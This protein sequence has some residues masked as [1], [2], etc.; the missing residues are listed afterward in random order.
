MYYNI[1]NRFDQ[2]DIGR[3]IQLKSPLL[4]AIFCTLFFSSLLPVAVVF[5]GGGGRGAYQVGVYGALLD[6]DIEIEGIFGA[7]V[8]AINAA[9]IISEGYEATR[10]LWYGMEY[11]QL[12]EVS[13]ELYK[14]LQGKFFS[15]NTLELASALRLLTTKGGIDVSPLK[16]KLRKLISEE[17]IRKSQM[18]FGVVAYS[19]SDVRPFVIYKENC[20]EGLLVDY[21]LA[22]ANF[23]AFK[24]EEIGNELFIDGGVYSNI[25]LFMARERGFKEVVAVDVMGLRIGDSL[26]YVNLFNEG[27]EVTL[28][29][30]SQ[31]YG[32]VMTFD[33]EISA[34][35]AIC[36]YLDTMKAFGKLAGESYFI[37]GD[38]DPLADRFLC[39]DL[40][41]RYE[42]LTLVGLEAVEK[43]PAEYHYY[44][45][46]IPWLETVMGC[47][48]TSPSLTVMKVLEELARFL[49][50][51]RLWPYTPGLILEEVKRAW[52]LA[53]CRDDRSIQFLTKY[54]K[55]LRLVTYVSE[56]SPYSGV[57][58]PD[59]T[60]FVEKFRLRL[61]L[62]K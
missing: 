30:P 5:S 55:L 22:S 34:K 58:S 47:E 62:S 13:P 28:L 38:S 21:V 20:P 52:E 9:G 37:F 25:P 60:E 23:P 36:G 7:S 35:Y 19:L 27:M 42:A 16:E 15:L 18:D 43:A 24:R 41:S 4:L 12:M 44:R 54:H 3:C 50:I 40:P 48:F 53:L 11:T 45:Q 56:K 8:G 1:I 17:K 39:L 6:L 61:S 33:G 59:F 14:L 26:A 10:D 49:E 2:T 29:E 31:Q 32:T 57:E 51:D 46:L